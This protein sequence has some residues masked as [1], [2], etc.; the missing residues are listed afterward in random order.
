MLGIESRLA[1]CIASSL[2]TTLSVQLLNDLQDMELG[3]DIQFRYR[4]W[5]M[6][7]KHFNIRPCQCDITLSTRCLRLTE[8]VTEIA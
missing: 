8:A 2:P 4:G 7:P 1:I 3:P 5:P 6:K